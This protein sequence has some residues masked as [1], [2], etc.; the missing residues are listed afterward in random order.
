MIDSKLA[1]IYAATVQVISEKGYDRASMD[2][3][4]N[5][6]GVAKGTLYYHFKNKEDLFVNMVQKGVNSLTELIR[7]Q[8][9][10]AGDPVG[11]LTLLIREQVGYLR[12]NDDFCK[13]L[14]TEVWGTEE[15]QQRF[16]Q[17]LQKYI[18][19]IEEILEEGKE[20]GDFT[21]ADTETTAAGI[22][23][24]ISI[25]ALHWILK[26]EAFPAA[27]VNDAMIGIILNGIKAR[28]PIFESEDN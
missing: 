15:R 10:K 7:R 5:V 18:R 14:L 2:E 19:L 16:R 6:S 8:I 23:G 17:G 25:A 26:R 4:A 28:P 9:K 22:F 11:K 24:G 1:R 27:R 13:I 20:T 21:F 12:N 3:I